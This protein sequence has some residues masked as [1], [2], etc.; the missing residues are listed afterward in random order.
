MAASN[1]T[2]RRDLILDL[3]KENTASMLELPV[4]KITWIHA[5][6]ISE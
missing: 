3:V 5:G 1:C 6:M 4:E 2:N